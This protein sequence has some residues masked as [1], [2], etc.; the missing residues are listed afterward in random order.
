M[1]YKNPLHNERWVVWMGEK[2]TLDSGLEK[3]SGYP[4]SLIRQAVLGWYDVQTQT[5]QTMPLPYVFVYRERIPERDAGSFEKLPPVFGLDGDYA[6]VVYPDEPTVLHRIDLRTRQQTELQLPRETFSDYRG[7]TLS[8]Q[9]GVLALQPDDEGN[10]SVF[11]FYDLTTDTPFHFES[12]RDYK[13]KAN[14]RWVVWYDSRND[15]LLVYDRN[16]K[17]VKQFDELKDVLDQL[18]VGD[19]LVYDTFLTDGSVY[20]LHLETGRRQTIL[21]DGL[22]REAFPDE[23]KVLLMGRVTQ[24]ALDRVEY[25][26]YD[27]AAQRLMPFTALNQLTSRQTRDLKAFMDIDG[28][29]YFVS[30]NSGDYGQQVYLLDWERGQLLGYFDLGADRSGLYEWIGIYRGELTVLWH[31]QND[32]PALNKVKILHVPSDLF[33]ESWNKFEGV[34]E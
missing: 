28:R 33:A 27:L 24:E 9:H 2:A 21:T 20:A 32:D 16:A 10:R 23:Q 13:W 31:Q 18:L 26:V 8:I 34:S 19:W 25:Y 3:P 11:H 7:Q 12:V 14:R 17:A 30:R 1:S 22:V 15:R 5:A 6:Y 29:I 4:D